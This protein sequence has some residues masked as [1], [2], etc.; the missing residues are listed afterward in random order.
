MEA[1]GELPGETGVTSDSGDM[2]ET[3]VE[4]R[5]GDVTKVLRQ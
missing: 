3:G 2:G 4:G 5:L 1:R